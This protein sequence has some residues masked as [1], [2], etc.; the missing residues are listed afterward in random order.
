EVG[1]G[2]AEDDAG[3]GA[4]HGKQDR[5][6]EHATERGREKA[7][8]VI[9]GKARRV[10]AGGIAA[11]EGDRD[12]RREGDDEKDEEHDGWK[13]Q[14]RVVQQPARGFTFH[15]G[16]TTQAS[17][18]KAM[19][20]GPPTAKAA[21]PCGGETA[22]RRCPPAS[23][24]VS[25]VLPRSRTKVTLAW[26]I[27]SEGGTRRISSGRIESCAPAGVELDA[28]PASRWPS[29]L[30]SLVTGSRLVEPIKPATK[31]S[32]GRRSI[33]RGGAACRMRPSAITTTRSAMVMASRWSWVT[34]MVVMPSCCCSWRNS[35]CIA[36]RSLASRA[37]RGSSSRK[38]R[39]DTAS[40]R[41]MATR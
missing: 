1:K 12:H 39:G 30:P 16:R 32:A 22:T 35:T 21:P 24:K 37:D 26:K 20:T 2:T 29:T 31:A 19:R 10:E 7:L 3:D 34:T 14:R 13:A 11:E 9:E 25:M 33:S 15:G 4:Q 8:V 6:P 28:M 5:K 36:S 38:S 27:P 17:G 41:A 40:A 23:T 18:E